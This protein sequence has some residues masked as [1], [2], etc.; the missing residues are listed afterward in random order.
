[1]AFATVRQCS[2]PERQTRR[3]RGFAFV[4]CVLGFVLVVIS[5]GADSGHDFAVGGAAPSLGQRQAAVRGGLRTSMK[6]SGLKLPLRE[7]ELIQPDEEPQRPA[8]WFGFVTFA[9][10][11]NGKA[12]MI[13]FVLLVLI[14]AITGQGFLNLIGFGTAA[15]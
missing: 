8:Y 2:G 11:F 9:E 15:S 7:S 13:G 4:G 12:A 6:A 1:M 5:S 14:E 3:S 10:K